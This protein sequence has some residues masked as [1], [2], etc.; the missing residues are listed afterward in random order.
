MRRTHSFQKTLMLGKIEGRRR[1]RGQMMRWLDGIADSMDMSLRKLWELVM[2]REAWCASVHGVAK[3]WTQLSDWTVLES[4][5]GSQG[6]NLKRWTV[7]ANETASQF[8]FWTGSLFQAYDSLLYFYKSIRSEVWYFQF[9][10]TQIYY[11]YKSLLLFKQS[12]CF[13]DSLGISLNIY[14]ILLLMC[15]IVNLWLRCNSY[16]IPLFITYLPKS[17]L[18][19]KSWAHYF[20]KRLLAIVS[21]KIPNFYKL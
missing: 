12:S 5:S 13:S 8:F 19:L 11:L 9:P 2:D 17:C 14:Y 21:L 15:P 18:P 3:N 6:F 1:R 20:L 10:L 16:Y 4:N 7:S